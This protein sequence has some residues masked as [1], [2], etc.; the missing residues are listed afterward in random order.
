MSLTDRGESQVSAKEAGILREML[1][2]A[3]QEMKAGDPL[4]QLD[5][6]EA[7]LAVAAADAEYKVALEEAKSD[8]NVRYSKAAVRRGLCRTDPGAGIQPPR[9]APWPSRKSAPGIDLRAVAAGDREGQMDRQIAGLK[10]EVAKAKADAARKNSPAARSPRRIDGIV[11]EMRKRPGEWVQPGDLLVHML[12][13]DHLKVE[14]FLKADEIAPR[15]RRLP[16]DGQR[17]LVR[18]SHETLT[19]RV[20][21]VS[22]RVESGGEYRVWAEVE[23]R[24]RN[25]HWVL[26]PD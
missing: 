14:G 25:G 16:G 18:G 2:R 12:R 23:N 10:A 7:K 3:G 6:V 4:A 9:P 22:P 8:V 5:D 26:R 19:G 11:V 17:S 1:V 15:S 24:K 21:F 13:I 20:V